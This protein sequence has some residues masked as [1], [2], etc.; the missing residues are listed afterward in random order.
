MKC[1]LFLSV[2]IFLLA[3][4]AFAFEGEIQTLLLDKAFTISPG[5]S[6]NLEAKTARA[7]IPTKKVLRV[8][9]GSKMPG[10]FAARGETLFREFE[11]LLEDSLDYQTRKADKSSLL[12]EGGGDYPQFA[13][14]KF[15][16]PSFSAGSTVELKGNIKLEN[17]VSHSN[18]PFG[19]KLEFYFH[20]EGRNPK[21]VYDAPDNELFFPLV[22]GS[23]LVTR[24]F[25]QF[26]AKFTMPEGVAVI[27]MKMGGKGFAGRAWIESPSMVQG[28]LAL[29][30]DYS[31][32]V[33]MNLTT[34]NWPV[35]KLEQNG[36]VLFEGA[37][38]DRSSMV[39]DFYIPLNLMVKEG[40]PLK[41]TLVKHPYKKNY[42]YEVKRIGIVEVAARS[43][44]VI[45]APDYL[46]A[47]KDFGILVEVNEVGLPL[48]IESSQSIQFVGDKNLL[49]NGFATNGFHVLPFKAGNVDFDP[50]LTIADSKTSTTLNSFK[51][52][53]KEGANTYLSVGDDIYIDRKDPDFSQY[54]RWM[55]G[56][57]IANF[58][59][60]RPSYQ[61]SG[62]RKAPDEFLQNTISLLEGLQMPFAWQVEGRN[63][64]ALEIN[65]PVE[66][67]KSPWFRGKQAHENDG[68][69]YYWAHFT[70]KGLYSD[71]A[72]RNRPYGGIFAKTRPIYSPKGDFCFFSRY[73]V[74]N[75]PDGAKAF[76]KNLAY[77]RGESTRHTGPTTLFR[78][79]YQAGYQ[80][81]GA[82][83]MYGPEEV[84]MA[85]NRGAARAYGKENYGSL[86]AM[87]WGSGDYHSQFHTSRFYLSLATSYINGSTDINTEDALYTDEWSNDRFTDSGKAH[88]AEQKKI[89]EYI[90]THE[91]RGKQV[92]DI[93][94]LQ[95][96]DC[97]WNMFMRLPHWNQLTPGMGWGKINQSFDL[98]DL[99]YPDYTLLA[100]G[101]V[102]R[103]FTKTPY[104]SPDILPIEAPVNV[105]KN[106]KTLAFL[107][108][109]SYNEEDFKNLE[110]FLLE[111]GNLILSDV[112]LQGNPLP[113]VDDKVLS[114]LRCGKNEI[115]VGKGKVIFFKGGKY[116]SEIGIRLA[117][118]KALRDAAKLSVKEQ[119]E[120]GWITGKNSCAFSVWDD[121]DLRTI[122]LIDTNW[123]SSKPSSKATLQVENK[124][125][126]LNVRKNEIET[127][128]CINDIAL[129]PSSRTTDFIRAT[130]NS[131][132]IQTMQNDI[133]K[134]FNF[135]TGN[136][137]EIR[138]ERAGVHEIRL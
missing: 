30:Q 55:I 94:I 65:P 76:V 14:A 68:A 36:V 102:T 35:W 134:R 88:I 61:W 97:S 104:G 120:K 6:V 138:I 51:I 111:G 19:I 78:Y 4:Q 105:L 2:S 108:W 42:D 10:K 101:P 49:E 74:D 136:S 135:K 29:K 71:I 99:F 31:Q 114:K 53:H 128:F 33:G 58:Y 98:L 75:I 84:L 9:G 7:T 132:F 133:I 106:Y 20:K 124:R 46:P 115:A 129:Q 93:A 5:E 3:S 25:S 121:A 103:W 13:F 127:L 82:E 27:I 130:D 50:T 32:W 37:L 95:G 126:T 12:F 1:I 62:A 22:E 45:S 81:T 69:Y 77:S 59:Q 57:G 131:V 87:Q 26:N 112:H 17:F 63:L 89:L 125:F 54:F 60:F 67:L 109:N 41:L 48:T 44:E 70:H 34:R 23:N 8:V 100:G 90:K 96:R 52:I 64:A 18:D 40:D 83:M 79:L 80:W 123:R 56:D 113:F 43:L 16:N 73:A 28:T 85:A 15:L 107:G 118:K 24:D 137:D 39:A 116:P 110:E 119:I 91:R 38:F 122:Y 117:Y 11:Y 92:N 47:N 21:D 66:K 86:H 72:A